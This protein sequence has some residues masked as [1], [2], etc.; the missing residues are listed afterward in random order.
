MRGSSRRSA[1]CWTRRA[2]YSSPRCTPILKKLSIPIRMTISASVRPAFSR[3]W[4]PTLPATEQRD[5]MNGLF[6]NASAAPNSGLLKTRSWL[7]ACLSNLTMFVSTKS[8]AETNRH[9]R[10]DRHARLGA[11]LTA[12]TREAITDKFIGQRVLLT[13]DARRMGT[14]S[15]RLMI[16]VAANLIARFC[17]KIDVALP[18]EL[19]GL[20]S[21]IIEMLRKI[22]GSP[23]AEFRSLATAVEDDYA[24]TLSIGAAPEGLP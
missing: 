22:D 13:G 15:G 17:P 2:S 7:S 5:G 18:Q 20:Q 11:K 10:H 8:M 21:E 1:T 14:A 9:Q 24:A 4:F 6:S 23:D 3:S 16:R 19:S 12:E